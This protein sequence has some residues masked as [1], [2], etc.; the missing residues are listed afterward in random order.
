MCK[1]CEMH[2][3]CATPGDESSWTRFFSQPCVSVPSYYFFTRKKKEKVCFDYIKLT[4]LHDLFVLHKNVRQEIWI[5]F[6]ERKGRDGNSMYILLELIS[7]EKRRECVAHN[8][9]HN[10]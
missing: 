5:E 8:V 7:R 2:R 4:Y 1:D 6:L 10:T 9:T 3:I